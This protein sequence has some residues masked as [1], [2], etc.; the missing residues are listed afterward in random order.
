M[1]KRLEDCRKFKEIMVPPSEYHCIIFEN[2]SDLVNVRGQAFTPNSY[3]VA[4][5]PTSEVSSDFL[6]SFRV[7]IRELGLPNLQ[8]FSM[9]EE[10]TGGN[11]KPA[12]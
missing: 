2:K 9:T 6:Y 3:L 7:L 12:K 4:S 8:R 10:D 11:V 5:G 1:E